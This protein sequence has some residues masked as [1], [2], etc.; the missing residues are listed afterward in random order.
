MGAIV[1]VTSWK[2]KKRKEKITVVLLYRHE[3][4]PV[5]PWPCLEEEN[6]SWWNKISCRQCQ[7]VFHVCHIY[8]LL[9]GPIRVISLKNMMATRHCPFLN[10][11]CYFSIH[12]L[13]RSICV[14]L[15]CISEV[16]SPLISWLMR[17]FKKQRVWSVVTTL[18]IVLSVIWYF[19]S[20]L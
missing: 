8:H 10:M 19:M 15:V 16:G 17:G 14:D 20:L 2:E 3:Y 9:R 13:T 18:N 4:E 6:T 5:S 7:V 1:I 12:F 11:L